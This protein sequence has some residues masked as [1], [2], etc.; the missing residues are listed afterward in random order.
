MFA[1][2]PAPLS[3]YPEG[4]YG[5]TRPHGTGFVHRGNSA[6]KDARLT[7]T[8]ATLGAIR[9]RARLRRARRGPL[10]LLAVLALSGAVA[11]H[12]VPADMHGM[13]MAAE[14]C[15]AVVVAAV[16]A[17]RVDTVAHLGARVLP[18]LFGR[19]RP[20]HTRSERPIRSRAGPRFLRLLVLRR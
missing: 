17:A 7:V 20:T 5:Y 15:L 16:A 14:L 6:T 2:S 11:V 8:P 9:V 18:Q 13:A 10:L 4:V 19:E 1:S 12:H 3:A